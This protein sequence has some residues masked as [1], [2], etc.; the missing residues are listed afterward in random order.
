MPREKKHPV[1]D[2]YKI[3]D[4]GL[5]NET[6]RN[7]T[8]ETENFLKRNETERFFFYKI[9]KR[10]ETKRYFSETKRNGTLKKL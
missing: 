4:K 7:E 2:Y 9:M 10:H 8:Q 1:Y 3:T 5:R 6:Q